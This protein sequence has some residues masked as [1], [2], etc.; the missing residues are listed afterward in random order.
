LKETAP[1]KLPDLLFHFDTLMKSDNKK[2]SGNDGNV[3]Y[4][5]ATESLIQGFRKV[6]PLS[7]ADLELVFPVLQN[8]QVK[9]NQPLTKEGEICRHMFFVTEGFLRMYYVD[10]EGNEI[11]YR[12]TGPNNFLVDYQSFLTQ[13]P[14][15]FYWQAMQDAQ[16]FALP[17]NDIQRIYAASPAW[18]N[19]G[20]LITERVYLD[21]NERVEM[22]LFMTPEERYKFLLNNRPELFEQVSQFHLSSFMGIK[23]E[24]LS[25][26]RKRMLKK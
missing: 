3:F 21:L 15:H 18:T 9:K 24:S 14:S 10:Q 8:V 2:N 11:N 7:D 13:K 1:W 17:Y 26:L 20:R 5:K 6:M 12:F 22:L 19:F 23:P 4:Q 16:L 25:R